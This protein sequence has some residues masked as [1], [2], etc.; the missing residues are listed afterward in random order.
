MKHQ[1]LLNILSQQS[2]FLVVIVF[3]IAGRNKTRPCLKIS[4]NKIIITFQCEILE[5]ETSNKKFE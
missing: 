1:Q 4:Q 5:E 3:G 2:S